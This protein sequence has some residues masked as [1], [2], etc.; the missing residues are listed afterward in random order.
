MSAFSHP[1]YGST[2]LTQLFSKY[3]PDITRIPQEYVYTESDKFN[4]KQENFR[5]AFTLEGANDRERKDDIRYIKYFVQLY[6]KED[7][8]DF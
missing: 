2:R 5:F 6:G 4:L 7:G 8:K 3:N 1:D